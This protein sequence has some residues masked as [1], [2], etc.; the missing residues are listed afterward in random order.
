VPTMGEAC[1]ACE[2][3]NA[4]ESAAANGLRGWR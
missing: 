4:S 2:R 1:H 3:P